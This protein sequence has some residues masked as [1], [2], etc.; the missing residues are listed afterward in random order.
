MKATL[1]I[2][3]YRE[4]LCDYKPANNTLLFRDVFRIYNDLTNKRK[5]GKC[6]N[7]SDYFFHSCN[8]WKI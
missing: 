5:D 4:T 7:N 3:G 6:F 1:D 8:F 2:Q